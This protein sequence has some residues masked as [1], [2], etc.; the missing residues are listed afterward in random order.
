MIVMPPL[1]SVATQTLPAASTASESNMLEA[2]EAGQQRAR[3]PCERLRR[4]LAGRRR[5][6]NPAAA[7]VGLGDVEPVPSGD[8]PMPFGRATGNSS[9]RI[10][11][12]SGLA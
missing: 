8:R 12:P 10:I 2:G 9:S 4:D 11:E 3:R 7:P 6:R 1:I 5:C